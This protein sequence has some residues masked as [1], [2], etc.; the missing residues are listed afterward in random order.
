MDPGGVVW[1][2]QSCCCSFSQMPS[3]VHPHIQYILCLLLIPQNPTPVEC[4][5]TELTVLRTTDQTGQ[6]SCRACPRIPTSSYSSSDT[7][8]SP[9]GSL[10]LSEQPPQLP[11]V[12]PHSDPDGKP[13]C[14]KELPTHR[15]I[16]LHRPCS[17]T[18]GC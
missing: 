8:S 5:Q 1:Q 9:C 7:H 2:W 6:S 11:A 14:L 15:T 12:P 13:L 18:T 10:W 16:T 3:A 17:L 4:H